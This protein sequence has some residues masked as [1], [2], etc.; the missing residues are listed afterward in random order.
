MKKTLISI[1]FLLFILSA[2]AQ[3]LIV[4][5]I[6]DWKTLK[7]PGFYESL[8]GSNVPN[9]TNSLPWFWG[10]NLSHTNNLLSGGGYHGAQILFP[11][12]TDSSTP[13]DMFI[14]TTNIEGKGLWA[15]V[16]HDKQTNWTL[17]SPVGVYKHN[18]F[19]LKPGGTDLGYVFS[20]FRMYT[21]PKKGVNELTVLINSNGS[22]FING[23]NVGIGTEDPKTKLDVRG[24]ITAAEVRVEVLNGADHVFNQDYDL[25]PLSEV[26]AFIKENKHLPEIPSEKEMRENGLSMN[27][28]QIKL[29]KKIEDSLYML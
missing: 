27:E 8:N 7:Y 20:V 17:G 21:A 22:S 19:D 2:F 1:V 15:K 24:V 13:T 23:G 29:L 6:S 4:N 10:L 5:R 28:F 14:R 9:T 11:V 16:L 12:N 25:K 18:T 26:A 3:N